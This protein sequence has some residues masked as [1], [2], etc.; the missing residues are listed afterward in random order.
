MGDVL[1]LR[2]ALGRVAG[3]L[4]S[5][6]GLTEELPGLGDLKIKHMVW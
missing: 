1:A 2:L 5:G 4:F 3:D 6:S